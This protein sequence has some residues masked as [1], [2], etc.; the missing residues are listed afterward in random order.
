MK[1]HSIA[2]LAVV[3]APCQLAGQDKHAASSNR[4]AVVVPAGTARFGPAPDILP[5]GATLAVLDGDPTRSGTYVMRLSMPDGYTIPPHTH[6]ADEHVTVLQGTFL[7]G[8]GST[9][10]T[11]KFSPLSAGSFGMLPP[12][13][14]H[15]ARARGATVIQLHGVGPWRLSYVN[16][17]DDPRKKVR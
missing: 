6:P 15:F 16:P 10:D 13:M 1:L 9:L 3:L 17:A 12:G 11:A 7:V 8:M 2:A 5:P 14:R 4:S